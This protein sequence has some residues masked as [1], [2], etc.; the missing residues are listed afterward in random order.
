[1]DL[2][3][4][5][6]QVKSSSSQNSTPQHFIQ[7]K[8]FSNSKFVNKVLRALTPSTLQGLQQTK[9]DRKK[10]LKFAKTTKGINY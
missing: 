7:I 10:I 2:S 4:F 5:C 9:N 8:K 3:K 1:M 6:D